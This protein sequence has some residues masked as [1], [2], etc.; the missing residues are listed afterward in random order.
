[1]GPCGRSGHSTSWGSHDE[2]QLDQ[3]RFVD[4]LDRFLGFSDADGKRAETNGSA[5]ELLTQVAE[6]RPVDLVESERV[7]S[8]QGK[9][10]VGGGGVDGTVAADLGVVAHPTKQTIGDARCAPGPTSD[11]GRTC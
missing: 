11:L 9:T 8:E 10:I 4:I 2:S 5:A 7:D 1:M 6:N 3:E